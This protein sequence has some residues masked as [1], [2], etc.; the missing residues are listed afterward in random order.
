LV[1]SCK[2]LF[3]WYGFTK[4]IFVYVKD[5]GANLNTIK[6][7]LKLTISC[8]TLDVMESFEGTCFEH[9][10]SNVCQYA[11]VEEKVFKGLKYVSIKSMKTYL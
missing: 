6:I 5:E 3:K 7:A 10:F 4:K 8:E 9:V 11:I 2:T 1:R